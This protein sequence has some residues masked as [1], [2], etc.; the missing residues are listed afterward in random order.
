MTPAHSAPMR[1]SD[2]EGDFEVELRAAAESLFA[3]RE[4]KAVAKA[5]AEA[6]DECCQAFAWALDNGTD[7]QA[8]QYVRDHNPRL[9][10]ELDPPDRSKA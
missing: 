4:A 6:W 3:V 8:I 1:R 7:E 9:R 5:Q 10:A 2:T